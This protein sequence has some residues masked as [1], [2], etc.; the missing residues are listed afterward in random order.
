MPPR[1]FIIIHII[2]YP[3]NLFID[4]NIRSN[5]RGSFVPVDCEMTNAAIRIQEENYKNEPVRF[6]FL[7]MRCPKHGPHFWGYWGT[8]YQSS[9]SDY[10][11]DR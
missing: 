5:W 6:G 7:Q 9:D 11:S 1:D 8:G 4:L 10:D 2:H 3:I